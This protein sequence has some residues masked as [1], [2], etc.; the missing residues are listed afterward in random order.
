MYIAAANGR[1]AVIQA[2]H[3]A[4]ADINQRDWCVIF[5]IK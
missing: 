5:A 2:L 1:T 4:R 3:A